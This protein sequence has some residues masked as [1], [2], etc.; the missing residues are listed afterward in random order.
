MN[1]Y[2]T[3]GLV[4]RRHN[5]GEADRIIVFYTRD[6][7]KMSAKA[8]GVRKIKS[9]LAGSLEPFVESEIRFA[10]GKSL[11]TIIGVTPHHLYKI[12]TQDISDLAIALLLLEIIERLT[13][14]QQPNKQVYELLN[15]SLQGLEKKIPPEVVRQYF[16]FKLLE[17]LGYLPEIPVSEGRGM[18]LDLEHGQFNHDKKPL[19][20][21][22]I[23][24]T[25]LK[26]WRLCQIGTLSDIARVRDIQTISDSAQK[27]LDLF[28]QY[29]FD[30]KFRSINFIR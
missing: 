28:Y 12:P 1:Y 23:T 3:E 11:D 27:V 19:P 13:A 24:P 16:S 26:L 10:K 6:Y 17:E 9:K 21:A 8:R 4:L 5:I 29:R 20:H 7:G 2:Q 22:R 30:L 18:W 15:E 14:E 25:M